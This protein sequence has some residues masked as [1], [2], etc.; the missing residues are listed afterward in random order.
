MPDTPRP[1]P[2]PGAG[3]WLQRWSFRQL[4]VIAFLLLAALLGA[5]SLR[6]VFTLEQLTLQSRDIALGSAQL[7]DRMQA[8]A[9]R[10]VSLERSS[11]QSVVL[12]DRV[13]RLRF[14]SDAQDAQAS[15]NGL[16]GA[17][18][19]AEQVTRWRE[20][21]QTAR[22]LLTGPPNT[23]FERERQL[24]QVFQTLNELHAAMAQGVRQHVQARNQ[25]LLEKLDDSR[26]RMTRQVS[27]A[28][29]LAVVMALAFGIWFTRPLRQLEQAIVD[30]GQNRLDRR[31]DIEGPAD[32]ALVGQR[33]NWLRLRLAELDA[34]KSRF[35]RH[36]SHELKTPLASMREGASL[37]E[38]GVGGSLS[39]EQR[40]IVRILQHNTGV[41]QH[42]IEDLLRFN[43]AAFEARHLR[44][45]PTDLRALVQAQVQAQQ[46]HWR[47]K[48]LHVHTDA[49]LDLPTMEL[50]PD[51]ID[52]VLANLLSNAIRFSPPGGTIALRL[53]AAPGALRLH[54][55]DQGPGVAPADR[56]R[57][58]EPFYKGEHQPPGVRGSG[59]GLSIVHEYVA[60]H[61]GRI[62]LLPATTAAQQDAA[63]AGSAAAKPG[64][65]FCIE[66]PYAAPLHADPRVDLRADL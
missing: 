52:T 44:R 11:R 8:L 21:L 36:I 51:K 22:Q 20:H 55:Q 2:R 25:A 39:A 60:A 9:E 15:L 24:A 12:D 62:T 53:E 32:L 4:L 29:A 1:L 17:G 27:W 30:L 46:L 23:A 33:L 28:I 40:E 13:L 31:I 47:A 26:R 64:A 45:R 35:L 38:D 66:L 5:A 3:R 6:A 63:S 19:T 7:N 59:I 18:V 49:P 41:L 48:E 10:S 42:Q 57:I 14:L 37:L 16:Q 65:H 54:V 61:G 34:D 58:F 43:A 56:T 50:D